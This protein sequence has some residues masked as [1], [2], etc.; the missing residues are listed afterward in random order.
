MGRLTRAESKHYTIDP[1]LAQAYANRGV[2]E[3]LQGRKVEASQDFERAFKIDPSLRKTFES[4]VENR[5][6]TRR[7]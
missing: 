7:P 6:K 3:T 4:F 2:I 5:L 1:N